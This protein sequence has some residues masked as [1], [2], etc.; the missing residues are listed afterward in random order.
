MA[1]SSIQR[2]Y[3]MVPLRLGLLTFVVVF[4]VLLV[5]SLIG[6]EEEEAHTE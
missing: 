2:F 6:P 4:S 5:I 3:T 1:S